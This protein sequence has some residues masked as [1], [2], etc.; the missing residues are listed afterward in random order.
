MKPFQ[1]VLRAI[2]FRLEGWG[3]RLAGPEA[4]P[5]YQLGALGY[6]FFWIVAA[7]G[8]YLFIP[9][10]T[11]VVR[12]WSSVE[13][14]TN[15]WY[16]DGILRS[17]HRYGSDAM[18]IVVGLHLLREF[19]LDRMTGARWFS[20]FSGIPLLWLLY[21][22]G[23]SGYW[24]V[25]DQLAQY[26][27]VITT[28]WVDWF[29]IF[30]NKVAGNFL[31][32]GSLTD[33]FFTLLIF[34]HIAVP[35][36][37]L[38]G[39]WIHILR[40]ARP[41]INPPKVM[42]MWSG[43]ALVVLSLA[44]PAVSHP[45]ADLGLV[46]MQLKLDWYYL[47]TYPMYDWLG[48]GTTWAALIGFSFFLS[49]FPW[50]RRPEKRAAVAVDLP[51]CNGCTRCA[52]VCPYGAINMVARTDG[53][54]Y[55]RAAVVSPNLCTS[56]GICVGVCPTATHPGGP[57]GITTGID[58]PHLPLMALR[59]RADDALKSL[60]DKPKGERILAFSCEHAPQEDALNGV[61]QVKLACTAMLPTNFLDYALNDGGAD[62]VL[63]TG[64]RN[65]DCR[66]R[67]GPQWLDQRLGTI[68]EPAVR[69][70]IPEHKVRIVWA[71][72]TQSD[73]LGREL[74]D[75][76]KSLADAEKK[77]ANHV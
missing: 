48:A 2:F 32:R 57:E 68:H 62:G 40:I 63:L 11:S 18:V 74:A 41:K 69:A 8:V 34:I 58:L 65:G 22:S 35:L 75:F 6:F 44:F 25:W 27:A 55:Q 64:C 1:A 26:I 72:P 45:E 28:E 36:F 14:I 76:R 10:E 47:P 61:A 43:L 73:M 13:A 30:G 31:M 7:T 70:R 4:N 56:C 5:L 49:L 50:L 12:S 54:P 3:D 52:S 39:A 46:P 60:Q 9:L 16:W 37:L 53:L 77:G 20:W 66:H 17:L 19:S 38:F 29:G 51:N 59:A 15:R 23:I 71:A 33:R 21:I 67:L 42:A 24:L